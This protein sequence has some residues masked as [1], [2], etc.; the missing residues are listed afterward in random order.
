MDK[1]SVSNNSVT[2]RAKLAKKS[3]IKGRWNILLTGVVL[4][5]LMA[6][7]LVC[8]YRYAYKKGYKKGEEAGKKAVSTSIPK[9]NDFLRNFEG[10][11]FRTLIGKVKELEGDKLTIET[12]KG[13]S[14]SMTVNSATKISRKTE[15]L[16]IQAL[17]KDAE[18]TVST[19]GD[20]GSLV[21]TRIEL[22]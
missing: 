13:L 14:K 4:F 17:K 20:E 22:R 5:V 2:G 15:K 12:G 6:G 10:P 1:S 9:P 18:V 7:L 8:T 11:N 19:S 21:A 16:D 3:F